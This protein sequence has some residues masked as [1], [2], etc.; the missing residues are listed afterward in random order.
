MTEGLINAVPEHHARD[1]YDPNKDIDL[2]APSDIPW[3]ESA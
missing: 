1:N 3:Q 2:L